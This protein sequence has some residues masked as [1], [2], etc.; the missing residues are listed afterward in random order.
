MDVAFGKSHNQKAKSE[1]TKP[2]QSDPL[3]LSCRHIQTQAI[4][5]RYLPEKLRGQHDF[6]DADL[7]TRA[8]QGQHT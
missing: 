6:Q 4:H 2:Y 7:V 1:T 3:H 8:T 5:L